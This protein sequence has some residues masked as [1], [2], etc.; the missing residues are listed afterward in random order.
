MQINILP[1]PPASPLKPQGIITSCSF[2]SNLLLKFSSILALHAM[3]LAGFEG[4][5]LRDDRANSPQ[6]LVRSFGTFVIFVA[7]DFNKITQLAANT[8][9]FQTIGRQEALKMTF[10]VMQKRANSN[11]A[12]TVYNPLIATHAPPGGGKSTFLDLV[13]S[14]SDEVLQQSPPHMAEILKNSVPITVTYN[15]KTP[16]N[17]SIEADNIPEFSLGCRMLYR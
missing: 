4:C 15:S 7:L 8:A 12:H 11:S 2:I 1:T 9:L 16:Y 3:M 14:R 17:S 13:L 10:E 5:N 6:H